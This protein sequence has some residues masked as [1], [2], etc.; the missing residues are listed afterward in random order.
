VLLQFFFQGPLQRSNISSPVRRQMIQADK[1]PKADDGLFPGK[2]SDDTEKNTH[3]GSS[4]GKP[5]RAQA[6]RFLRPLQVS[7]DAHRS[8]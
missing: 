1:I 4:S 3:P 5:A 2:A 8:V 6:S 7:H